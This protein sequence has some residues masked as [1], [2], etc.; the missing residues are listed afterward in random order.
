[1]KWKRMEMPKSMEVES[2]TLTDKYGKFVAEPFERG[3]GQ[4]V[5]TALR[6]VLLSS[7]QTAAITSMKI[8]NVLHEFGTIKGV[9]EDVTQ[10]ILNVKQIKI[11]LLGNSPRKLHLK[12]QGE[13]TVIAGDI[14]ADPEVEIVNTDLVIA[15]LTSAISKLEIEFTIDTGRGYVVSEDNKKEDDAIGVIPV[16]A[17]FTPVTRVNYTVENTRVGQRTDFEKLILE[18][19]TDGRIK[20]EDALSYSAKI[21]KEHLSVFIGDDG[22]LVM[23]EENS[24]D[25]NAAHM[26]EILKKTVDELELSV[27]SA[28][29]LKVAG[30]KY[31]GELVTKSEP[32]MLKYRNFGKKSLKEISEILKGMGLSFNMDLNSPDI[33]EDCEI[34]EDVTPIYIEKEKPYKKK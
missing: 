29:C 26:E 30:I 4:T 5:G 20:P 14:T 27:R 10:I 18:I 15:T 13:K 2:S 9:A 32:E 23:E 7:I 33:P 25:K 28:N 8:E 17:I 16:D 12:V 22:E 24:V 11:K 21:M 6:R 31:I 34:S 19:W 1:M 3:Y